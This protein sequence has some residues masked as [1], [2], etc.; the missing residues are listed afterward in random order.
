[1][2]QRAWFLPIFWAL[3]GMA[4]FVA[5][6]WAGHLVLSVSDGKYPMIEGVYR[7]AD[8]PPPDIL[9]VL[10]A[11][12]FPPRIMAEIEVSHSVVGPPRAWPSPRT[13]SSPSWGRP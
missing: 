13:R 1:M 9:T 4:G 6:A 5:P 2:K 7:V 11:S 3:L 8:P 12:S 10:D